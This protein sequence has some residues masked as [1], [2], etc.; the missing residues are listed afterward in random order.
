MMNS[1]SPPTKPKPFSEL[2]I[3]KAEKK[4]YTLTFF[5]KCRYKK[6]KVTDIPVSP[7]QIGE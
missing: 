1:L 5:T 4:Q 2:R 6:T 3:S 7:F